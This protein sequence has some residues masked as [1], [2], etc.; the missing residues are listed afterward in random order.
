MSF[1]ISHIL[2]YQA[3]CNAISSTF[4]ARS[5]MNTIKA[6]ENLRSQNY[7]LIDATAITIILKYLSSIGTKNL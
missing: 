3:L 7:N 2:L 6:L 1:P 5:E 4:Y